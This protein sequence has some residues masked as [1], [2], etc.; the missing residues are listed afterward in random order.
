M[1]VK[2]SLYFI[3]LIIIS[4]YVTSKC[5]RCIFF[6][7]ATLWSSFQHE[8]EMLVEQ[9]NDSENKMALFTTAKAASIQ[10]AEDKCQ[11]YKVGLQDDAIGIFWHQIHI[12]TRIYCTYLL[13]FAITR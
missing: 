5:I 2:I 13:L 6:R 12:N 11:R 1:R 3:V 10:Q 9:M 4:L 7:C 8:K